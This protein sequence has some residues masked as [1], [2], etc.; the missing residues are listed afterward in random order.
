MFNVRPVWKLAVHLT[1]TGDVFDGF[2]CG[3]W[4]FFVILVTFKYRKNR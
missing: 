2:R 4:L 1:V 3:V